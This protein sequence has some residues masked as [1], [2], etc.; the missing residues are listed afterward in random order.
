M[1]H[2]RATRHSLL[3]TCKFFFCLLFLEMTFSFAQTIIMSDYMTILL[4]YYF[5]FQTKWIILP[6]FCGMIF[7]FLSGSVL[8][9]NDNFII[10]HIS[11]ISPAQPEFVVGFFLASWT[12]HTQKQPLLFIRVW[13][14]SRRTRFISSRNS[15]MSP[16]SPGSSAAAPLRS[17][18]RMCVQVLV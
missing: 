16:C 8:S 14:E 11:K 17:W 6:Y 10:S 5:K 1:V 7:F 18:H 3:T 4:L 13:E 2:Q 12:K 9:K 15:G